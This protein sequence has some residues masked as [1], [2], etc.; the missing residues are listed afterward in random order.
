MSTFS[1]SIGGRDY[2]VS[3][4]SRTGDLLVLS[5]NGKEHCVSVAALPFRRASREGQ[6]APLSSTEIEVRAPMPGIVSAVKVSAGERVEAGQTLLV[7]EAMKMENPI[8]SLR[9]GTIERVAVSLGAEVQ[10]G[11]LLL[12]FMP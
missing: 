4:V 2:A 3:L 1:I 11:S 5:V 10:G 12:L 7:I 9:S 6:G 8:R